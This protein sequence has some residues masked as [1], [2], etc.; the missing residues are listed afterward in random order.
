MPSYL[1]EDF[2][3]QLRHSKTIR[4]ARSR[5]SGEDLLDLTMGWSLRK[6][7]RGSLPAASRITLDFG[8]RAG[9]VYAM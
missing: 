4:T 6:T 3:P 2:I 7:R 1:P 9:E 8:D 5:T